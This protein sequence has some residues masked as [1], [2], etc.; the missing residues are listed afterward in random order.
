MLGFLA[1]LAFGGVLKHFAST[2]PWQIWAALGVALVLGVSAWTI[3]HRAY[4]RGF[5]DADEK[6]QGSVLEERARQE[7]VNLAATR[8]AQEE[9]ERLRLAKEVR[10]ATIER[11]EAEA[12]ADANASRPAVGAA[13]VHRLNSILH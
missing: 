5:S 1:N 8:R 9:I 4:N 11:L 2:L 10:D 7:E 3:D 12:A 13:S 6:W